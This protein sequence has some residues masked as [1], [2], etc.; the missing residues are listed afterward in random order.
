MK[1]IGIDLGQ[2]RTGVAV[3]DLSGFLAGRAQTVHEPNREKLLVAL[4][5]I[6][7]QE[8][9]GRIVVGLPR[10]QNGDEGDM[11]QKARAFAAQLETA[12]QVPTVLWDERGSTVSAARLLSDAGKRRQKQRA[13]VDA[14]AAT[15]IL[16]SYLDYWQGQK[17]K[18]DVQ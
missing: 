3:S 6:I 15:I 12:C 10:H 11:A 4:C 1:M 7:A 8:K 2:V 14:V 16:Q 13:R 18:E 17:G 5:A 9:P